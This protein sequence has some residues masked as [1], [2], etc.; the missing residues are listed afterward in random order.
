MK[1]YW[2]FITDVAVL[3]ISMGTIVIIWTI[4]DSEGIFGNVIES[5][6]FGRSMVGETRNGL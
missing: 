3:L 1:C 6:M 4:K 5:R 2:R